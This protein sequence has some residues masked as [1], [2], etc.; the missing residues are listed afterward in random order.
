MR[1]TK[2]AAC[3]A[4]IGIGLLSLSGCGGG[5]VVSSSLASVYRGSYTGTWS[6]ATLNDGGTVTFTVADTGS[7]NGTLAR[8]VGSGN[9]V[10]QIDHAGKLTAV[11]GETNGAGSYFISGNVINQGGHLIS[12]FV[13]TFNG[14]QYAGVLDVSPASGS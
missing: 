9:L 13:F 1:F 2:H 14:V 6:S 8:K 4:L 5:D 7:L 11:A 3:A 10:G 12:N